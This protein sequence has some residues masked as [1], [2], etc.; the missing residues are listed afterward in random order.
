M[1]RM[2]IWTCAVAVALMAATGAVAQQ[3]AI[4]GTV[5]QLDSGARVVVL[6]DGRMFQASPS[7]KIL[8]NNQPVSFTALRPGT[9]VVLLSATPVVRRD[10]QYVIITETPA[11]SSAVVAPAPAAPSAVI[12]QPPAGT[13]TPV[14]VPAPATAATSPGTAV[15]IQQPAAT[16]VTEPSAS[17]GDYGPVMP[18]EP[19]DRMGHIL[20]AP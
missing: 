3:P 12:V 15:I 8:V 20:Q 5:V 13:S 7:T 11:A 16:V 9:R 10:N 14:V 18:E 19:R 17:Y 4:T 2:A 6:D 1:R